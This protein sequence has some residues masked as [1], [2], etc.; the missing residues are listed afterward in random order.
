MKFNSNDSYIKIAN[1]LI[2]AT[3]STELT[4]MV[5][6]RRHILPVKTNEM[7]LVKPNTHGKGIKL[8]ITCTLMLLC[9]TEKMDWNQI[10]KS[11]KIMLMEKRVNVR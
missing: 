9:T 4:T 10:P 2:P 11:L 1:S 5:I 8:H 3:T 7:K 6:Y